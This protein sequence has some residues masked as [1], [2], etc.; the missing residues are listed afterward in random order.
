VTTFRRHPDHRALGP[1][2][3]GIS[4]GGGTAPVRSPS[5]R[6]IQCAIRPLF[7]LRP[8]VPPLHPFDDDPPRSSRQSSGRTRRAPGSV[9]SPRFGSVTEKVFD[10]PSPCRGVGRPPSR[11]PPRHRG[12]V[13]ACTPVR[14]DQQPAAETS[15]PSAEVLVTKN[16]LFPARSAQVARP[17]WRSPDLSP[18]AE[19]PPGLSQ[20]FWPALTPRDHRRRTPGPGSASP[21][22]LPAAV[23]TGNSVPSVSTTSAWQ[24]SAAHCLH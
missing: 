16:P 1:P 15:C 13:T 5:E 9:P 6:P 23:R 19:R 4:W 7:D 3:S 14:R 17:R 11:P 24:T 8:R 21:A 2:L 10:I 22:P 18:S 20:D 12:V